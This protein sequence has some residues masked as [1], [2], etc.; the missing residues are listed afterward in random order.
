ML[1]SVPNRFRTRKLEK[2]KPNL[3][4]RQKSEQKV[5][6]GGSLLLEVKKCYIRFED[7]VKKR[8]GKKPSKT[9]RG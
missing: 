3:G 2:K 4:A 1:I 7:I 8:N 5:K 9:F 6:G